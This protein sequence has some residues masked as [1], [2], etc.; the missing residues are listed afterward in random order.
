MRRDTA[1]MKYPSSNCWDVHANMVVIKHSILSVHKFIAETRLFDYNWDTERNGPT[2]EN[3]LLSLSV[4]CWWAWCLTLDQSS[5]WLVSG[6]WYCYQRKSMK[7]AFKP[8]PNVAMEIFMCSSSHH[9]MG[10]KCPSR[11]ISLLAHLLHIYVCWYYIA[12]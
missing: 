2:S 3:E 10:D 5:T 12:L 8:K 4:N 9:L 11:T 6:H 1:R 7:R